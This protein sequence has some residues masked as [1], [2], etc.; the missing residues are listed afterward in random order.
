MLSGRFDSTFIKRIAQSIECKTRCAK[1][2]MVCFETGD[3][4][5]N[6][7]SQIPNPTSGEMKTNRLQQMRIE[8]KT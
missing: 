2:Q 8:N 5:R 3:F 7:P 6:F 1:K 4:N